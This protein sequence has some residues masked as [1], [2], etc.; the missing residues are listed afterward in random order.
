MLYS[1]DYIQL[2]KRAFSDYDFTGILDEMQG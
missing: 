1:T 2:K